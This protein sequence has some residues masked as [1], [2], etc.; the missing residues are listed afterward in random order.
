MDTFVGSTV[1]VTPPQAASL[2][3]EVVAAAPHAANVPLHVRLHIPSHAPSH[4]PL[5]ARVPVTITSLQP[6]HDDDHERTATNIEPHAQTSSAPNVVNVP[7][8]VQ[9]DY[10]Q[11]VLVG[12]SDDA[13]KGAGL[14]QDITL[15]GEPH[16]GV[17]AMVKLWCTGTGISCHISSSLVLPCALSFDVCFWVC[18][19]CGGRV[20]VFV[21][22]L[23]LR[24]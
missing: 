23:W 14:Q 8:P 18:V 7:L 2:D 22:S 13:D 5:P 12:T 21:V 19:V 15:S 9:L 17:R 1:Q 16:R 4:A 20:S 6:E 11:S 10:T 24:R 3:A